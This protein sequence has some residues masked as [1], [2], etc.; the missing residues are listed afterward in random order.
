MPN[1]LSYGRLPI[2]YRVK[3]GERD[4]TTGRPVKNDH[5][6]IYSNIRGA[7]GYAPDLG[8][9]EALAAK[10]PKFNEANRTSIIPISLLFDDPSLSIR[11][12]FA[13]YMGSKVTPTKDNPPF[14]RCKGNGTHA[15]RVMKDGCS[16]KIN[17]PGPDECTGMVYQNGR[18][19]IKLCK[20]QGVFD[21]MI[22]G[23]NQFSGGI[24]RYRTAG[25]NSAAFLLGQLQY[26]HGALG[27]LRG[28]PLHIEL[29]QSTAQAVVTSDLYTFYSLMISVD[30][31]DP[32]SS[33]LEHKKIEM[34]RRTLY[35]VDIAASEKAFE[36]LRGDL[37]IDEFDDEAEGDLSNEDNDSAA[38]NDL[39]SET[40]KEVDLREKQQANEE[41]KQEM[42]QKIK[43][44]KKTDE[45]VN[46]PVPPAPSG[47]APDSYFPG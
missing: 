46:I 6:K 5:L 39:A 21:F 23:V 47:P 33:L 9:M 44:A 29:T 18:N 43:R 15:I 2:I 37:G 25:Y 45:Q 35:G 40:K 1:V 12:H 28:L 11:T 17:C 24:A 4:A 27:M 38:L 36:W 14:I 26:I 16:K 10:Y 20:L 41:V 19:T 3:Q 34:D 8:A 13:C 32:I 30:G 22:R 31:E 7:S 42:V